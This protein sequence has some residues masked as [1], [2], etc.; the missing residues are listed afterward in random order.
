MWGHETYF[1]RKDQQ[2]GVAKHV[3]CP[4]IA[5][6]LAGQEAPRAANRD[7]LTAGRDPRAG[8]CARTPYR[9]DG[10]TSR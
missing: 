6:A 10:V 9:G 7:S 8:A 5:I 4:P 2:G 3:S 1:A